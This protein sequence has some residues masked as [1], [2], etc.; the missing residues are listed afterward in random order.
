MKAAARDCLRSARRNWP[1]GDTCGGCGRCP[2]TGVLDLWQ[3]A[4]AAEMQAI[5]RSLPLGPWMA[6]PATPLTSHPAD[7]AQT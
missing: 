3:A 2:A 5:L 6:V 4:D 1:G 7:P